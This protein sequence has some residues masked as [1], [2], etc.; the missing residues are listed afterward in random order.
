MIDVRDLQPAVVLRV[1]QPPQRYCEK[2]AVYVAAMPE[3][4]YR[5]AY[6]A[7]IDDAIVQLMER[8]NK[9]SAGLQTYLKLE[10]MLLLVVE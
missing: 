10:A 3:E 9:E 6:H 1:R 2:D 4:H 8:I 7:V 5:V